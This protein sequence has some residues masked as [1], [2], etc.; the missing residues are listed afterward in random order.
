MKVPAKM[1]LGIDFYVC[2][3]FFFT[4]ERIILIYLEK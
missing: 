1:F 3:L 4:M 2:G